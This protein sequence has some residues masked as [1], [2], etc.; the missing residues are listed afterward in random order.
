[1][2][3]RGGVTDNL[4]RARR[5][6]A[7]A[8]A[9]IAATGLLLVQTDPALAQRPSLVTIGFLLIGASSI[10][11]LVHPREAWLAVEESL[12][13]L[14]AVLIVGLDRQHVD[15]LQ[16]LWLAAVAAG[17]LARGGRVHWLGRALLLGALAMPFLIA[18]EFDGPQVGLCVAAVALLLTC[19]RVTN[20]L[21]A[22]L[23]RARHEADHDP[24]TGALSRA[25]FHRE[26]A[27]RPHATE[28]GGVGLLIVD[29]D[30]FGQVNKLH[31]HAAGDAVLGGAAER[32]RWPGA[33]SRARPPRWRRARPDRRPERTAAVAAA[34]HDALLAP[35]GPVTLSAS[36]GVAVSPRHGSDYDALLRA[37][38]V[39]LRVAKR[40]GRGRSRRSPAR[41][42]AAAARPARGARS[43]A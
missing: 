14:A 31:G 39:A 35:L 29:L 8:R 1:M 15:I 23:D 6:A 40:S 3:T 10:V 34:A 4:L 16:I 18:R 27:G 11:Q 37:A 33:R 21:R 24:L 2:P 13:A 9:A 7:H 32:L 36:I 30:D 5:T 38:D 19:G 41:T 28:D 12:A 43:S 25:A 17:V 26:L 42:S 22:L 20:E